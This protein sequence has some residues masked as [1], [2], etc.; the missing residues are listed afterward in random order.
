[1]KKCF[2]DCFT[3]NDVIRDEINDV[4]LTVSSRTDTLNLPDRGQNTVK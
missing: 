1:M 2:P 3:T 4:L